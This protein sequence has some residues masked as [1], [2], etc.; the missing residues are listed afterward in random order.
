M[1]HLFPFPLLIPY[2]LG[3]VF[4]NALVLAAVLL[5][6]PAL[7]A[8]GAGDTGP[9]RIL[10]LGDSL[11]AGY[12]LVLEDS[13]P[14][15]LERALAGQEM[16]VEVI[17]AGVSGDTTAG[18]LTRL[19]WALA[20]RPDAVIVELGANDGL[21]GLDPASTAAN[22]EAILTR[23]DAAGVGVLLTGMVAP[24][25]LGEE[26]GAEFRA[27]YPRL[28]RKFGIDLYP[29]FLDGVVTIK[30]LNQDDDLHPNARGVA[31]IV[32]RI[33]PQVKKLIAG[34]RRYP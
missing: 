33:L 2:G 34:R 24:P 13:F 19:E 22:L 28:A 14:A 32:E 1:K 6:T 10:V 27:I 30:E 8:E 18:G 26:Y 31:V 3:P 23:L 7:A 29:F 5:T 11:S 25:N 17:N 9:F 4:V 21:R 12:G 16:T 20:D 15:Q